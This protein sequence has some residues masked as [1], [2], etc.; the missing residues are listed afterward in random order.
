M[1]KLKRAFAMNITIIV[2]EIFSNLWMMSGVTLHGQATALS[3]ARLAMFKY[4]TVDSNVIMGIV[5]IIMARMQWQILKGKRTEISVAGYLLKL[6][7]TVGVTLTMLVT[8]FFL[9]PTMGVGVLLNS[10]LFLHVVNPILSIVSFVCLEKTDCLTLK[11]SIFGI[12]TL[13]IYAVYYVAVT[14]GHAP[15]GIIAEGYDWYGFFVLGLK[16]GFVIVPIIILITYII[17]FFLWKFNR[18]R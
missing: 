9:L 3:A 17:S 10:N 15:G 4:Y 8:L 6:I 1:E 12:V 13:V 16:S 18:K 14:V 11:H 2:L 7:G 5:A